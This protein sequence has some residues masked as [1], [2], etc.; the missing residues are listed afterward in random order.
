MVGAL[1]H[2]QAR[3]QRA[4][5]AR[6]SSAQSGSVVAYWPRAVRFPT[7]DRD[8]GGMFFTQGESF[9]SHQ[10]ALGNRVIGQASLL[11]SR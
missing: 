8:A 6:T 11:A 4:A 1:E 9:L 7:R 5:A 10:R 3:V 2:V